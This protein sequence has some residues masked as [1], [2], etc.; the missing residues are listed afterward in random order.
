MEYFEEDTYSNIDESCAKRVAEKKEGNCV[1]QYFDAM[2][3]V[4][5]CAAPKVF[6]ALR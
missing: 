2:H 3:C 5:H 6:K 1:G 4:D